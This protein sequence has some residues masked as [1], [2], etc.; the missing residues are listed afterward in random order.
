MKTNK[1]ELLK[2]IFYC[3]A[4]IILTIPRSIN[5]VFPIVY[6]II[7]ILKIIITILIGVNVIKNKTKLSHITIILGIY[8]MYLIIITYLNKVSLNTVIKVYG[9]NLAT[10]LLCDS[11]FT[12]NLKEKF[13]RF[14]SNYYLV[15]LISNLILIF[16]AYAMGDPL[17]RIFDTYLLGQDNRFILYIIPALLGFFYLSKKKDSKKNIIKLYLTYIVGTYTVYFLWSVASLAVLLFIGISYLFVK[18]CKKIKINIYLLSFALI[19]ICIGL[20]F[21]KIQ[22]Y[23]SYFIVNV[24]NKSITLSYRTIIWDRALAMLGESKI[25][26]IFG[27][28]YFDTSYLFLD[29]LKTLNHL[30]NLILDPLFFG[31]IIGTIIYM[32]SL[33]CVTKK[34]NTTSNTFEGKI[35]ALVFLGVL[36]LLIFDTFEA[37]QVYY[38]MIYLLYR[39]P[40]MFKENTDKKISLLENVTI[41]EESKVGILL[42]TYNGEKYLKEQLDSIIDQTYKN[43]IIYI[44]DDHST[45]NTT[46]IICEYKE[47]YKDKIVVIENENKL[48]SAKMNFANLFE[49]VDKLDYYIFCD[50]D[51]VWDKEK[52]TKL[53]YSIKKEEKL[54]KDLPI[55]VYSDLKIVDEKLDIISDSLVRYENKFLPKNN[56]FNHILIENYFPGC[57]I[58]F[59]A[60]LKDKVKDIYSECE[61]HDWWLTLVAAFCG[62]IVYIDEPLHLYRQHTNNTIGAKRD[63][64]IVQTYFTRM[65]KIFKFSNMHN[66]WKK[67]QQVTLKQA[68]ELKYRYKDEQNENIEVLNK[69]IEIMKTQN[70]FKRFILLLK[71]KYIP[72]EVIRIFRLVI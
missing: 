37:Y 15:L 1:K 6:D 33:Y 30:H 13:I 29:I 66:T 69:F 46:D 65:K 11:I 54:S 67:Y 40:S 59:N 27:F 71:N 36:T 68:E 43:W 62:K 28:G 7:N 60:K 56:I 24:L 14:F 34:I 61:M 49:K 18:I 21:F 38:F 50:Q 64:N 12:S 31:G 5:V 41:D 9:L 57:A 4:F 58:M 48:S 3:I 44:S 45:D 19:L 52:I 32:S 8:T 25:N 26:L 72:R 63:K 23:F 10:L 35:V 47:L 20:V 55:L 16:I 70:R 22:N 42:A 17:Y 53:L 2:M 39:I 51:D